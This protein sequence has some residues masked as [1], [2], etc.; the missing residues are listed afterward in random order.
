MEALGA[1]SVFA[2]LGLVVL[3]IVL[4]IL[5]CCLPFAVFGMKPKIDYLIAQTKATNA[6]L[7]EVRD[8]LKHVAEGKP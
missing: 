4:L 8:I 3:G 1:F 6:L 7:T 2:M 5:W